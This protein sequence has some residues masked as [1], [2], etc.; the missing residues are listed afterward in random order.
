[1]EKAKLLQSENV[2]KAKT[3]F[4]N[5]IKFLTGNDADPSIIIQHF[6]DVKGV[7]ATPYESYTFD[8]AETNFSNLYNL[9]CED[10]RT[11]SIAINECLTGVRDNDSVTKIRSFVIDVDKYLEVETLNSL[12]EKFDPSALVV[13]SK[14]DSKFKVHLYFRVNFKELDILDY[15][16]RNY[17]TI[18]KCL[19]K[20]VNTFLGFDACDLSITKEKALRAPGS[21]HQKTENC[22]ISEFVEL[23]EVDIIDS[24]FDAFLKVFD[25]DRDKIE[26]FKVERFGS[27]ND[28]N[29]KAYDNGVERFFN[30]NPP[31]EGN[32]HNYCLKWAFDTF[33]EKKVSLPAFLEVS[34]F[35][36]ETIADDDDY[37]LKDFEA[38]IKSAHDKYC[39]EL[40]TSARDKFLKGESR[41]VKDIMLKSGDLQK[42]VDTLDEDRT[43]TEKKI[44]EELA[45]TQTSKELKILKSYKYFLDSYENPISDESVCQR[46][47]DAFG[48]D[49]RFIEGVGL[50]YYQKDLGYWSDRG[51]EAKLFECLRVIAR[52]M[53]KEEKVNSFVA[54]QIAKASPSLTDV[55]RAIATNIAMSTSIGR[56]NAI[57]NRIT[58]SSE[59]LSFFDDF[60]CEVNLLNTPTG[61]VD[62]KTGEILPHDRHY[63]FTK[64]TSGL[65]GTGLNS[66]RWED[67]VNLICGGDPKFVGFL[68]RLFGSCLFGELKEQNLPMFIGSGG[69]GKSTLLEA[70]RESLGNYGAVVPPKF[71]VEDRNGADNTY[72]D[73]MAK[74][75]AI[76]IVVVGDM[77]TRDRIDNGKLKSLASAET[78]T[79]RA[80]R[81]SS[82]T[83][84]PQ[85]TTFLQANDI[86]RCDTTD[87]GVKRRMLII[88][89]TEQIS[90]MVGSDL[91]FKTS[92][93]RDCLNEILDFCVLGAVEYSKI[94]LARPQRILDDTQEALAEIDTLGEFIRQTFVFSEDFSKYVSTSDIQRAYISFVDG[95]EYVNTKSFGILLAK[96]LKHL[97]PKRRFSSLKYTTGKTRGYKLA[98][99]DDITKAALKR[100]I[101]LTEDVKND[102]MVG[103]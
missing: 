4:L 79:A 92:L 91:D 83:F 24:K 94:G 50:H 18:Q 88:Q 61:V 29:I 30:F 103:R 54:S 97:Y 48:S 15:S 78:I 7:N 52:L 67:T 39:K 84:L 14:K 13:S 41:S 10:S 25:L 96:T 5:F 34:Q 21:P 43:D 71:V 72:N 89:F 93:K 44:V 76:R 19:A 60:D 74:L 69:N 33:V 73:I 35:I 65:A 38:D 32:R 86:P 99:K 75:R 1:M 26:S 42:I 8:E 17:N 11:I 56:L 23:H 64:C 3:H 31:E 80:L 59:I 58:K 20:S 51:A 90:Q 55:T 87:E 85:F 57:S 6:G 16:L 49:F 47:F 9:T 37:T 102:T 81:Q 101:T 100:Q 95:A 77:S 98:Y 82:F 68:R 36:Y 22:S 70:V 45:D 12:V 27:L 40:S 66:G 62:L 63:L 46:F 28:Q 53:S 2:T